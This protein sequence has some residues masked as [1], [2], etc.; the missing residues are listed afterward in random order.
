MDGGASLSDYFEVCTGFGLAIGFIMGIA[1]PGRGRRFFDNIAV[2]T[3]CWGGFSAVA[4]IVL[5]LAH[6]LINIAV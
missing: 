1:L 2:A 5:W 6:R 3:A 4:A